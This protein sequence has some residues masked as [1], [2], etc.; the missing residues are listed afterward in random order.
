MKSQVTILKNVK[1][2]TLIEVLLAI[3]VLSLLMVYVFSIVD[4]STITKET[5]V[6]EDRE[7]VQVLTAFDRIEMDFSQIF[8][9]LYFTIEEI[10]R[11]TPGLGIGSEV[12]PTGQNSNTIYTPTDQFPRVSQKRQPIPTIENENPTSLIFMTA[13]N[14]RKSINA[15]ESRYG[16][17]SYNVRSA[18]QE[19]NF[20]DLENKRENTQNLVRSSMANNPYDDDIDWSQY[21]EHILLKGVRDFKFE[22]WNQATKRFVSLTREDPID[23]LSPRLIRV[24]FIWVSPD[25]DEIEFMK[26]FRPLW[27]KFDRQ[28]E[29]SQLLR[30]MQETARLK[31]QGDN[32]PGAPPFEE[33]NNN[34]G[35]F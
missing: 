23:P 4:S 15:P 33:D 12:L 11:K 14:R 20:S 16:W 21:R 34:G 1:G 32:I 31:R 9:P 35:Q 6:A 28:A 7:F 3:T 22:F 18:E 8:S 2:F 19:N 29:Q 26:S 25:G 13:S 10:T 5:I 17:V 24:S 27:P 30:V